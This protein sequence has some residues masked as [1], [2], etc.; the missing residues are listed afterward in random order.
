V[1]IRRVLSATTAVLGLRLPG[2]GEPIQIFVVRFFDQLALTAAQSCIAFAAA[3]SNS[4]A[5]GDGDR[6]DHLCRR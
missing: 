3:D 6:A 1:F 2:V 5:G 4:P